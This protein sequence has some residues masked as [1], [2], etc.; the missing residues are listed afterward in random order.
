MPLLR[1]RARLR[2]FTC[3]GNYRWSV[4]EARGTKAAPATASANGSRDGLRHASS[5]TLQAIRRSSGYTGTSALMGAARLQVVADQ[6]WDVPDAAG[7]ADDPLL[8]CLL[9]VCRA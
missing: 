8:G 2:V 6:G 4:V 1:C 9:I 7:E 5:T 3:A